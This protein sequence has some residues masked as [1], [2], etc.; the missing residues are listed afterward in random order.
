MVLSPRDRAILALT[1]KLLGE[2]RRTDFGET[3]RALFE[4]TA[5]IIPAGRVFL[6]GQQKNGSPIFGSLITGVG[7]T[8]DADGIH[9]VRVPR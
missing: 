3:V 2:N 5:T 8:E 9:V 6:I 1:S 7:L 4:A